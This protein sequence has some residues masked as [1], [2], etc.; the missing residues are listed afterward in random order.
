MFQT[1][2]AEFTAAWKFFVRFPLP[3]FLSGDG[4][5]SEYPPVDGH[6]AL[7]RPL[8]PLIGFMLGF[9]AAVPLWILH[10]L[11]SGRLSAG[12]FGMAV[13]PLV[14]E[15]A[16]SWNGLTSLSDFLDQRRQG[17]SVEDALS[18]SE[19]PIDVPRGGISMILMMTL[20][21]LR[22]V[23]CGILGMCAP[24][25]LMVALTGAWL[26]RAQLSAMETADGRSALYEVPRGLR[27]HHWYFAAGAMVVAGF[28][29]PFGIL[30]GFS[31]SWALA[32]LAG[33]ICRDSIS[34]V[35][36]RA[37]QVF[38]YASELVLLFLGILF[39]ASF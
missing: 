38:G 34:G 27:K 1:L 39:Y 5:R 31:V 33:N 15:I 22:M 26:V 21:F 3:A 30:L 7:L 16:G 20:Y 2:L 29:H 10:L 19:S 6:P 14:L 17:A 11:P 28:L 8:M 25:W 32:C 24:F 35:N 36:D 12:I 23:F 4:E 37:V 18:A 13:I 9:F